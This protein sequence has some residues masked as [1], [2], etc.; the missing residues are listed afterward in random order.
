M[1]IAIYLLFNVLASPAW[2]NDLLWERL[3]TEPNL[4][5]LM[6]HAQ[7]AGGHPLTWDESGNCKGESMLTEA[8]KAHAKRIGEEFAKRGLKPAVISSPMCRCRDTARLAFGDSVITDA[9]LREIATAD[10]ERANEFER[11][12]QALIVSYLGSSPVV[13]VSHRPNIDLL[14][15]ELI[16][17]GELLVGRA[18]AKGEIN[19]LGKIA[20]QP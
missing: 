20:V 8:G 3:R 15:L 7:P 9:A 10:A 5:V 11:K 16:S 12:A 2:A 4:V 18:T 13:F 19:V 6:R 1:R 14:S 17:D